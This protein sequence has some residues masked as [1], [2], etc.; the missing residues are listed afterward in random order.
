MGLGFEVSWFRGF[1]FELGGGLG[2]NPVFGNLR[3]ESFGLGLQALMGICLPFRVWILQQ[4]TEATVG[5]PEAQVLAVLGFFRH[6]GVLS[7]KQTGKS[8]GC[9]MCDMRDFTCCV[10]GLGIW[11][12]PIH[13]GEVE[14]NLP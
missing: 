9:R 2:G 10:S 12:G 6:A 13:C 14:H 8:W 11:V 3:I 1:D 5:T 4:V 7:T